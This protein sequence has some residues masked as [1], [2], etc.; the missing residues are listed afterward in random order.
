[1]SIRRADFPRI[2]RPAGETQPLQRPSQI[3][4]AQPGLIGLALADGLTRDLIRLRFERLGWQ[5]VTAGSGPDALHLLETRTLALILLDL[6]LPQ[7][8]G[9]E[10]L[11]QA[12]NPAPAIILSDV[13]SPEL[14]LGAVAAGA[15]GFVLKPID[16][17]ALVLRA[18]QTMTG[19]PAG[20][21]VDKPRLAAQM[22][23]T[24]PT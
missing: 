2:S 11:R 12:Q 21:F 1:M 23:G 17:D 13:A 22:P 4:V 8:N 5:V 6:W 10:V 16:L 24:T 18:R 3:P 7:V 20:P 14:V 9:L 15:L 19:S